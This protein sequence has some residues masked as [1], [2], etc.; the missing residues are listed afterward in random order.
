MAGSVCDTGKTRLS[1]AD[2]RHSCR[3]SPSQIGRGNVESSVIGFVQDGANITGFLPVELKRSR[4]KSVAFKSV[5]G[6]C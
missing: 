3:L 4:C 1:F 5:E 6:P 2:V